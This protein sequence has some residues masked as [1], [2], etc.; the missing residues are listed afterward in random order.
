MNEIKSRWKGVTDK[1][2]WAARGASL[3]AKAK[4][5]KA[6][7]FPPKPVE[8]GK[9]A[10]SAAKKATKRTTKKATGAAKKTTTG[11]KKVTNPVRRKKA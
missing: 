4:A 7:W 5:T 3:A 2:K 9:K 6:V 1:E 11:A 10:A 8:T